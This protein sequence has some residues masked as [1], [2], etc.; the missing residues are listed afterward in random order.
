MI[1]NI[2][3][4]VALAAMCIPVGFAQDSAQSKAKSAERTITGCV[5]RSGTDKFELDAR[6]G[7]KWNLSSDTIDFAAHSG[8]TVAVTGVV[9]RTLAHNLKEDSKEAATDA[10]LKKSDNEHGTLKVT[11]LKMVSKSCEK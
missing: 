2:A 9:S 11:D 4:T 5:M 8:H 7:S 6:D 3:L 10:H 1:R